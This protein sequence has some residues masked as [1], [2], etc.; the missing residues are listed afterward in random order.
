MRSVQ[1]VSQNLHADFDASNI[2][3]HTRTLASNLSRHLGF[4]QAL[5]ICEENQWHGV[6]AA[7][8]DMDRR[9]H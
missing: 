5:Q 1:K 9:K 3:D 4:D 6:L 2:S 8:I 7:L